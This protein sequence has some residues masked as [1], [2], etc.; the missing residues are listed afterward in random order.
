MTV[1]M[2]TAR[3]CLRYRTRL[4]SNAALRLRTWWSRYSH[5]RVGKGEERDADDRWNVE[6][7]L[8]GGLPAFGRV[9]CCGVLALVLNPRKRDAALL[10]VEH[11]CLFRPG[12]EEE[13]GKDAD[14]HGDEPFPE[15]C[16]R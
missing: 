12:R 11:A 15:D 5:S 13:D 4:I 7:A 16:H 2:K 10:L 14:N 6:G 9:F 3:P 1:G 8:D